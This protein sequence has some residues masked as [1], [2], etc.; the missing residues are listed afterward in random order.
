[1]KISVITPCYLGDYRNAGKDREKKLRRCINSVMFQNF[2]LD[3]EHVIV[4]DGCDKTVDIVNEFESELEQGLIKL[5]EIE[6]QPPFSGFPR[7]VGIISASGDW[8]TYLDADDIFGPDH[9]SIIQSQVN[10]Y[11]WVFFNDLMYD[12]TSL[13][14]E[15]TCQLKL[16]HCGTSNIAHRQNM[17]SRWKMRNDYGKDDWYFIQQLMKESGNWKKIDTPEYI[18]CHI[19]RAYDL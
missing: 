10:G 9:L 5:I 14:K 11:D 19:P 6:K 2:E 17:T 8:V 4:S 7:N 15:R 13:F 16:Y 1:M 12:G 3:V 18:V